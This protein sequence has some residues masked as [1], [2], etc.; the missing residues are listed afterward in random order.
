MTEPEAA[1]TTEP[2]AAP[3]TSPEPASPVAPAKSGG[4]W[5]WLWRGRA[6]AKARA[7]VSELPRIEQQRLQR[8]QLALELAERAYDPIEPLRTG[9]SLA[10]SISLYREAI[11]WG[12][13][14]Q[15]QSFAA[16]DLRDAFDSVPREVLEFAAGG[17]EPLAEARLALVER[18]FVET[19]ALPSETLLHDAARARELASALL[20]R[21]L[22]P[23]ALVGR[24]LLQRGVRSLTALLLVGVALIGGGLAVQKSR[25]GPDLAAGRPWQASSN[26]AKCHP[27]LHS[28]AG[29]RTDIFFNTQEEKSPW[30]RIDLGKPSTFSVV[31][32]TNRQDCCPDRALPL[33][34]V[35]SND[36]RTWR[37]VARRT[38]TFSHW[39]AEWPV[40]TARYVRLR[41]LRRTMLHL[42][43]VAVRPS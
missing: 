2:K 31:E 38:E 43:K 41:A 34:V 16:A 5:E 23:Q 24:L 21:K 29:N 3:A 17:Q 11:Y 26:L 36:D 28:C 12:L 22:A 35:V 37:A 6:L 19:A 14:A 42:E 9:S 7:Y 1:A 40:Q 15:D 33:V 10:L 13:L 8:A 32:V 25:L 4:L 20:R 27:Q 30:L 18:S 39:R